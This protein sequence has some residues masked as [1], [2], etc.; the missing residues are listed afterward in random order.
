MEFERNVGGRD[1]I[2]R[3]ILGVGLLVV[4]HR[5]FLLSRRTTAIAAILASSGLLFNAVSG[6]CG[7]NK[8]LG[9]NTCPHE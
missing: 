1:R 6:R 7:L 5:A 8:L 9:I 2:A 4:A 3:A